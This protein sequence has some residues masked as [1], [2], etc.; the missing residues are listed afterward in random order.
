MRAG[1][2]NQLAFLLWKLKFNLSRD[3]PGSR[4][5]SQSC[6]VIP[7]FLNIPGSLNPNFLVLKLHRS[8]LFQHKGCTKLPPL[9]L[10]RRATQ[11]PTTKL[12]H[13][14][15]IWYQNG[16]NFGLT[17]NFFSFCHLKGSVHANYRKNEFISKKSWLWAYP[18]GN[19]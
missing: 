3:F 18:L 4:D 11:K 13:A 19:G 12:L 7:G 8:H 6:P 15:K 5:L 2:R 14:F 1:W 9:F 10:F 16:T 17:Q